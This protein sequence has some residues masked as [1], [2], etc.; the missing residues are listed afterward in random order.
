M[1][2]HETS[3]TI[4][5][6]LLR[7][8]EVQP[9]E[10]ELA[11]LDRRLATVVAAAPA[12]AQ[13]RPWLRH[14]LRPLPLLAAM[15]LLT[16]VVAAALTLL[17]R[18]ATES[19]QGWR[20]AWEQGEVIALSETHSGYTV[21]LERAYV[22][23]NQLVVFL[24]I[25]GPL[26]GEAGSSVDMSASLAGTAGDAAPQIST[27]AVE[28]GLAAVIRAWETPASES[29]TFQLDISSLQII[30]GAAFT[31]LPP[32]VT[33]EWLFEFQLPAPSGTTVN[34]DVSAT[35]EG[36]TITLQE[37]RFSPSMIRGVMYLESEDAVAQVWAAVIDS[38]R[39]DGE[40]ISTD[41]DANFSSTPLTEGDARGVD[42]RTA[43]GT[44]DASGSWEIAISRIQFLEGSPDGDDGNGPVPGKDGPW[45]LTFMVP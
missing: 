41:T 16:G 1:S 9:T 30:P 5:A 8:L 24:D 44:D 22:D 34:P 38:V 32:A 33:G 12:Q 3:T 20:L 27:G 7:A 13:R 31:E 25:E 23:I 21:T 19:G 14:V 28:P 11:W 45:V 37:V 17:E 40:L 29:G 43:F 4:E 2:S 39:H 15:L 35:A 42:F 36:A 26:M 10:A 6:R 18:T